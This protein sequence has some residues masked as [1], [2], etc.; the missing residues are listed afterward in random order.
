MIT[1]YSSVHL[2]SEE[3]AICRLKDFVNDIDGRASDTDKLIKRSN[4]E[5]AFEIIIDGQTVASVIVEYY[6]SPEFSFISA[7]GTLPQHQ[8][9]GYCS[10]LI[11]MAKYHMAN[12][13]G[14]LIAVECKNKY[15][16]QDRPFWV[17]RGFVNMAFDN[18]HTTH[19]T[20]ILIVD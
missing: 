18:Q 15:L 9:N 13:G 2:K 16:D 8:R 7:A 10:E 5:C 12:Q 1:Q 19:L 17:K 3:Y 20:N 14:R 6:E 4:D 11:D